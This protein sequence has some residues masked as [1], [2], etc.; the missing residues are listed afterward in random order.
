MKLTTI[1]TYSF[2]HTIDEDEIE[3][4]EENGYT[5]GGIKKG[6]ERF[7]YEEVIYDIENTL[8]NNNYINDWQRT[9]TIM[10]WEE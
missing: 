7:I 2:E 1:V 5:I 9:N 4:L 3:E 6:S 10:E 8:D